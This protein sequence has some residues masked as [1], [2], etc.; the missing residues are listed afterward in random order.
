MKTNIT[1][2]HRIHLV[3]IAGAGLSAI[4]R[5]LAIRGH[6][7]TGSD[8]SESPLTREL[9]QLGVATFVGHAPQQVGDCEMV[10]ASSAVP[11]SNPELMA[12]R[13]AG[14][15]VLRRQQALGPLTQG[16][17]V[18]AVAGTHGKTTTS[19]MLSVILAR[20]GRDPSFIVGGM[21]EDLGTNARA[22]QGE[23]FV[24]EADEY[25]YAFHGLS[26]NV[27]V[28]TNIEMDHPDCYPDL[29]SLRASFL[30]FLGKVVDDGL[31]VACADSAE[32]VSVLDG[33]QAFSPNTQIVTYG[34]GAGAQYRVQNVIPTMHGGSRFSIRTASGA[35]GACVLRVPG[36]HNALNATAAL[37][38]AERCGVSVVQACEALATFQGAQR[39]FQIK[40]QANGVTVIDDYAHHPTE[41]R[42]TLA[43]A[44]QRYPTAS[45]WAVFQP[46]TY[47]RTEA[48]F[49]EFTACFGDADH[50]IITDVFRARSTEKETIRSEDLVRATQ[51]V[52]IRHMTDF[53]GIAAHLVCHLQAGD[54]ML[55][56]G[57][58]DGYLIG[59]QVLR[60]LVH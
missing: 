42:A 27:A 58:G 38:A 9:N 36:V 43:A 8:L 34:L 28:V 56:L 55:T 30:T 14:I 44:R 17:F 23:A 1:L 6:Q 40:G 48:L 4:A 19:A 59:E 60:S 25:D 21:I 37:I 13:A 18:V 57:A 10:I 49:S 46:H 33:Q 32:L 11:R 26:P 51:H 7:V 47:S 50:V 45:V 3:G 29:A 39:R 31:I 5:V 15:P 52:D 53:A 41:I 12:A 20:T 16:R 35:W 54:V 24:V 2:P 22:G